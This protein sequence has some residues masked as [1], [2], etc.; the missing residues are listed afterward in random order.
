MNKPLCQGLSILE[1][2]K[3]AIYEFLYDYLHSN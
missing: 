3:I 1:I 2:S